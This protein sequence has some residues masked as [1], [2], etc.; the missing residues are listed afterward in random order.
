MYL[1]SL[2]VE[3]LLTFAAE[4][5]LGKLIDGQCLCTGILLSLSYQQMLFY[6]QCLAQC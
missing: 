5:A 3:L 2:T 6:T 1:S 4:L